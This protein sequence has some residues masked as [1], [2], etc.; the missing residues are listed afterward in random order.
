[1]S[2]ITTDFNLS[3]I[4]CESCKKIIEK[5]VKKIMDVTEAV[6][7]LETGKLTIS[8]NRNIAKTE[9]IKSLDGTDYI[10]N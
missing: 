2:Q 6:T 3:G 4:H 8:S 1:M 7:D 10:V 9:I 5:R